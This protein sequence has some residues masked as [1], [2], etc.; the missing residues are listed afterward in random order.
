MDLFRAQ[1][2][3]V[4]VGDRETKK[5]PF[6]SNVPSLNVPLVDRWRNGSNATG[7]PYSSLR[8]APTNSHPVTPIRSMINLSRTAPPSPR[9]LRGPPT[10]QE[11]TPQ[12]SRAHHPCP[13]KTGAT[14]SKMWGKMKRAA[15]T[16]RE[17]RG[18]TQTAGSELGTG[19]WGRSIT[20]RGDR[21]GPGISG[22]VSRSEGGGA[23][24][25]KSMRKW[26]KASEGD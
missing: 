10:A 15:N 21:R 20:G 17:S 18:G 25:W 23:W 22:N 2:S 16:L 11:S 6:S 8:G 12:L 5:S 13:S 14:M 19:G 1:A 9:S 24:N 7:S 4:D 3:T 26:G